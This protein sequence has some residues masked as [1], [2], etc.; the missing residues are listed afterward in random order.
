MP[1][2]IRA[3]FLHYQNPSRNSDKVFNVFLV[4]EGSGNFACITEYG[5]RQNRLVRKP[6]CSGVSLEQAERK[7]RQKV[8]AKRNHRDT[9]YVDYAVGYRISMFAFENNFDPERSGEVSHQSQQSEQPEQNVLEF[10][11]RK[12]SERRPDPKQRGILNQGQL[13]SL[14]I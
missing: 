10:P 4:E 2:I 9:P 5:R 12:S 7:F 1:K 3:E 14:E 8:F 6:L 13:D 11:G